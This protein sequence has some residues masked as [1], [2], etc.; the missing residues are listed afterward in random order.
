MKKSKYRP[1]S[2][3]TTNFKELIAEVSHR[4]GR[5]VTEVEP[6]VRSL[7]DALK[8]NLFLQSEVNIPHFAIF[9]PQFTRAKLWTLP[10]GTTIWREKSI[11]PSV[12]W[13]EPFVKTMK[14]KRLDYNNKEDE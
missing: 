6:I 7:F 2:L 13:S 14:D 9:F 8:S 1:G 12:K 10:D 11:R 3:S 5:P 4:T